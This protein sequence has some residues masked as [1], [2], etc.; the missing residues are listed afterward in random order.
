VRVCDGLSC[1]L[2]G[3]GALRG[4]YVMGENPAMS[5]PAA[6]HAREALAQLDLLA[7]QDIF[8]TETVGLA[9]LVLPASAFAEK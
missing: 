9:D 7:V 1:R 4:L 8:V 2:A 3:A 5:N 6:G